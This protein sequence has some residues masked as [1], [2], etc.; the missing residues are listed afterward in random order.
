M[1]SYQGRPVS[2]RY[3]ADWL[4]AAVPSEATTGSDDGASISSSSR[5]IVQVDELNRVVVSG[6]PGGRVVTKENFEQVREGIQ[7]Q[8]QLGI[9][10]AGAVLSGPDVLDGPLSP[11]LR[12]VYT[13]PSGFGYVLTNSLTVVFRGGREYV[14]RCSH[15]PIGADVIDRG[16]AEILR[17]AE[18]TYQAPLVHVPPVGLGGK[19]TGIPSQ[20]RL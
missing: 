14:I 3:P 4:L 9:E 11:A 6:F 5:V 18:F 16:C 8:I 7:A 2:F 20:R 13:T 1:A 19:T 12:W 17:T 15:I 10:G